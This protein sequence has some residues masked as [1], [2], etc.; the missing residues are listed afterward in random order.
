MS[1]GSFKESMPV[2]PK[3]HDRDLAEKASAEIGPFLSQNKKKDIVFV[4]KRGNKKEVFFALS[5]AIV[6]LLYRTLVQIS[7]GNA[8]TIV[9]IHAELTTQQA[10]NLL[11]VSR[12]YLIQLLEAGKIPFHKVGRHRRILFANLLKY[13]EKS[14]EKSRKAREELTRQAQDL[15]LGY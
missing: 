7:K 14:K 11:N 15:D 8:V 1:V 4:M 10:A 6:T 9:P 13:R 3:S 2:L 5:P 12:P